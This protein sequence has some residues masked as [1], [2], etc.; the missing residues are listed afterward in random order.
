MKQLYRIKAH[1]INDCSK[2]WYVERFLT[3]STANRK[4]LQIV[5]ENEET[6]FPNWGVACRTND[7]GCVPT[8]GDGTRYYCCDGDMVAYETQIEDCDFF[9]FKSSRYLDIDERD[10]AERGLCLHGLYKSIILDFIV[11][12]RNNGY[13]FTLDDIVDEANKRYNDINV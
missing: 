9:D 12:Y 5:N 8:F 7:S 4:M 1:E 3:L 10:L 11:K 6:N 2:W 13:R